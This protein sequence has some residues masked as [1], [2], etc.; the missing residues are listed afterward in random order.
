MSKMPLFL[1]K[2]KNLEQDKLKLYNDNTSLQSDLDAKRLE[3]NQFRRVIIS[4][5]M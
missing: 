4:S 2:N 3:N 1:Q 5:F